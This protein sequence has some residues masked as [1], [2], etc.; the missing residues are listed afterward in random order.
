[1]SGHGSA[2]GRGR[3][4]SASQSGTSIARI[5]AARVLIRAELRAP[6]IVRSASAYLLRNGP[7]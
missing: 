1:M 6:V 5:A 2:A 3:T 7:S 4:T